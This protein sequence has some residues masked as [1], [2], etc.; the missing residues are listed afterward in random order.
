MFGQWLNGPRNVGRQSWGWF[1][2]NFQ[3]EEH[4]LWVLN[5]NW[6]FDQSSLLLKRWHPL[7]DASRERVDLVLIW[8]RLPGLPLPFW[9]EEHFSHIGNLLGTYLETD[10]SYKVTKLK[11]VAKILVKINIRNGIPSAVKMDWGPYSYHQVLDYENVPFRCR[12]CNAYGHPAADFSL[13]IQTLNGRRNISGSSLS[14]EEGG[15]TDPS[16][17]PSSP[18]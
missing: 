6:S 7:F 11:T 18:P 2:F 13:S 17:P 5:Q 1:A 3:S 14:R 12:R 15:C 8:D 16:S 10:A 4:L 9:F